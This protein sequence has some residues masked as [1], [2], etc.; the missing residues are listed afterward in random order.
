MTDKNSVD[1]STPRDV[2]GRL[3]HVL[4]LTRTAEVLDVAPGR[5]TALRAGRDRLSGAQLQRIAAMT[6]RTWPLW[7]LD[8]AEGRART[9]WQL[10]IVAANRVMRDYYERCAPGEIAAAERALGLVH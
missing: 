3:V 4:G 2:V 5:F 8:A 7:A 10:E 1:A 6:R 9:R